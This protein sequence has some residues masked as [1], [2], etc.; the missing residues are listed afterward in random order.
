MCCGPVSIGQELEYPPKGEV[1]EGKGN[2]RGLMQGEDLDYE[3]DVRF[4]S[5]A[6]GIQWSD[7]S[8]DVLWLG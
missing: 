5:G 6:L 2:V 1:L 8:D 3:P 7:D 4:T